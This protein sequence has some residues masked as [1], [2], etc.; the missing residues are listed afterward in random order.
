MSLFATGLAA[1]RSLGREGVAVAG[2]DSDPEMPGFRSRYCDAW[3]CPD[4]V[5]EPDRLLEFLT[6]SDL[7]S[8]RPVLLPAS[9]AFVLFLSRHREELRPSFRFLL[10]DADVLEA[11]VNK[12][13]QYELADRAGIPFPAVHYPKTP[14][15]VDEVAASVRYPVIV[16]P[17][18]GH[19]WRQRFGG[20]HKGFKASSGDEL[21]AALEEVRGAGEPAMVQEVVP[22]PNTNHFKLSAYVGRTGV[23]L[24]LFALRKIRQYPP[25]FGVG[26]L[27]ESADVPDV[28]DLGMRFLRAIDYRGIGSVEFK[29]DERDGKLKLIELNA[30][31]WQQNSLATACGINF[32]LIQ[33]RDLQG[34]DVTPETTYATG[35]RWL[36]AIPDFQSFWAQRKTARTGWREWAR[37]WR[38]VR[39]FSTFALD[40]LLPFL[41]ENRYGTK[42][43]RLPY[44]VLKQR[45]RKGRAEGS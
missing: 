36:D 25:E 8:S 17:Y 18:Y 10:P 44:Y 23:P 40:D 43:L 21:R 12:R 28:T 11:L 38:G 24:A 34:E 22:G 4:P 42:Y 14:G 13:K 37:S 2:I 27:V 29:R 41:S 16:K 1:V 5:R 32:P 26:C 20:A 6:D 39:A 30:R 7:A 35:I 33:L 45:R 15:E 19:V 31:L 3:L 9:D